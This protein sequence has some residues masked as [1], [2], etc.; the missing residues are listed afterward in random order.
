[1]VKPLFLLLFLIMMSL[2]VHSLEESLEEQALLFH[3]QPQQPGEETM[4]SLQQLASFFPVE[5]FLVQDWI[6]CSAGARFFL[7]K[8]GVVEAWVDGKQQ[9]LSPTPLTINDHDLLPLKFVEDFLFG[10]PEDE[11][12]LHL[13]LLILEKSSS[14]LEC[15]LILNNSSSQTIPLT[16]HTGQKYDLVVRD[17]A[18]RMITRW[19]QDKFFTQALERVNLKGE[20]QKIWTARLKLPTLEP[21]GYEVQA[22][23]TG[24]TSMSGNLS[25]QPVQLVVE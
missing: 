4:I 25:S 14:Y 19:S 2:T 7:F 8:P 22:L 10:K 5:I 13:H 18:G 23:L 21:G 20:S 12:P 11:G 6:F 16:F 15:I 17:M 9:H 24:R 1:M 3:L